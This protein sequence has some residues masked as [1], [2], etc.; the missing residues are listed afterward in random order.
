MVLY[1]DAARRE[2]HDGA[3]SI[4]LACLIQKLFTKNKNKT[5]QP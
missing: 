5:K 1:F 2:K 3:K 4:P